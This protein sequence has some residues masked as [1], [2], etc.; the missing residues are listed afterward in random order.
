MS[1]KIVILLVLSVPVFGQNID[2]LRPDTLPGSIPMTVGPHFRQAY[3][4]P[5]TV[6]DTMSMYLKL[7]TFYTK[8]D[9]VCI[10]LFESD[11]LLCGKVDVPVGSDTKVCDGNYV[12]DILTLYICS[13]AMQVD[14]VKIEIITNPNII[15]TPNTAAYF[16][17]SGDLKSETGFEYFEGT[18]QFFTPGATFLANDVSTTGAQVEIGQD[19]TD[20][21][22]AF[23]DFH[24]QAS[25]DAD[26]RIL[27][28]AG[29][30]GQLQFTNS[31]TGSMSFVVNGSSRLLVENDGKIRALNYTSVDPFPQTEIGL[32]THDANGNFSSVDISDFGDP[33]GTANTVAYYTAGG[34]LSG[35]PGFEYL[36]ATNQFYTPGATFLANDVSTAGAAVEIGQ[37]RTG[38]GTAFIDFHAQASSDRDSRI[39]RFGG[40]NGQLLIQNA[41]TGSMSFQLN[42]STRF[43]INSDGALR[44]LNYTSIDPFPQSEIAILTHDGSGNI[45]SRDI[46]DFVDPTGPAN[47]I[48]FFNTSGNLDTDVGFEFDLSNFFYTPDRS[49]LA[50]DV[51]GVGAQVEIGQ[52][53]TA[54]GTAFIDLHSDVGTDFEFRILRNTGPN[55]STTMTNVGSGG[56]NFT[57]GGATRLS[58]EGAAGDI[59]VFNDLE[60]DGGFE[61]PTTSLG[62]S[63]QFIKANGGGGWSW[64]QVSWTHLSNIPSGFADNVDNQLSAEQVQDIVGGMVSGNTESGISV[65]YQDG[66]GTLDF[67]VSGGGSD[68]DGIYD[69]NGIILAT[70]STINTVWEIATG[71][72]DQFL[73]DYADDDIAELNIRSSGTDLNANGSTEVRIGNTSN[74]SDQLVVDG[75]ANVVVIGEED[76]FQNSALRFFNDGNATLIAGNTGDILRLQGVGGITIGQF[77]GDMFEIESGSAGTAVFRH[78]DQSAQV[79]LILAD[80]G[81]ITLHAVGVADPFIN[82]NATGGIETSGKLRVEGGVAGDFNLEV[83]GTAA[84]TG[85]G[86]W[87]SPSDRRYK[88]NIS[89]V[90]D[91]IKKI[92]ALNPVHFEYKKSYL[93]QWDLEEETYTGWIAQDYMKVFP[94]DVMKNDED[95]LYS[96]NPE[97][98]GPYTV[99]AVQQLIEDNKELRMRI[100]ELEKRIK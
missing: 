39:L 52:D 61:D 9:S 4:R 80:D 33:T 22:T 29:A 96:L 79:G 70:K 11:R 82:L 99:A 56:I 100:E 77:S 93:E 42:G 15:G 58:I 51:D 57:A 62:A 41:G 17:G 5:V 85:G 25:S 63:N 66:D 74:P 16:D 28:F 91:P 60:V 69:G 67:V 55:G 14:S 75:G 68:G 78:A 27:R 81:R 18:D 53:R 31:G 83:N 6:A 1:C 19:R 94:D 21:G 30:N 59:R 8:N 3:A 90:K 54:D 64:S 98:V 37:D 92:M 84:K 97:A 35:E 23:I 34:V 12:G 43:L 65:T 47:R 73:V 20:D 48:L 72:N 76:N 40:T 7:D 89:K 95:G 26:A 49:F 10:R 87:S 13:G 88:R 24:S 86:S 46:D 38:D 32:V 45:S 71:V 36:E 50:N 2:Q 44:A